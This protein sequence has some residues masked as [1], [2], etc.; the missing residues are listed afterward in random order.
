MVRL[1]GPDRLP[2]A[3]LREA[4][5]PHYSSMDDLKLDMTQQG[6]DREDDYERGYEAGHRM[7]VIRMAM[8]F[9]G[10]VGADPNCPEAVKQMLRW[11]MERT[12]VV[13]SLRRL[14]TDY[15]DNDWDSN[16]SLE[17][18][19]EKHLV[20]HLDEAARQAEEDAKR[21]GEYQGS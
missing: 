13:N 21:L 19:I 15:G 6:E 5:N 12:E 4:L 3:R 10:E 1:R 14:C 17:D 11:K 7:A 20:R 8:H 18:V 9:L 2:A 16:L